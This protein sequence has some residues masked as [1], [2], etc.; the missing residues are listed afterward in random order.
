MDLT[1]NFPLQQI[2]QLLLSH[3][4]KRILRQ[5]TS[6]FCCQNSFIPPGLL[7]QLLS[8]TSEQILSYKPTLFSFSFLHLGFGFPVSET[9]QTV[10]WWSPCIRNAFW[11]EH[12]TPLGLQPRHQL[13]KGGDSYFQ[14]VSPICQKWCLF[15]FYLN[16]P[17]PTFFVWS[18]INKTWQQ[19]WYGLENA[20]M[21]W[22]FSRFGCFVM[23]G[24][25]TEAFPVNCRKS[26]W[27]FMGLFNLLFNHSRSQ[28]AMHNTN[29]SC[30]AL[31]FSFAEYF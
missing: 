24:A 1:K 4:R 2:W 8:N 23:D 15:S 7:L 20:I 9:K 6:W 17:Y 18:P 28:Y 21:F 30:R 27:D 11:R 13:E 29:T 14:R 5:K 22:L 25:Y 19:V 16:V 3:C 26:F 10:L 31:F 12:W